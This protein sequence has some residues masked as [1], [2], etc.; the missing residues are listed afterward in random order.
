MTLNTILAALNSKAASVQTSAGNWNPLVFVAV[1]VAVIIIILILRAFGNSSRGKFEQR[2]FLSGN[3]D[4][5]TD[6]LRA[7]NVYWGFFDGLKSVYTPLVAMHTG[8]IIDYLGIFI[9]MLAL[10][11]VL[12]ILL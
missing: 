1:F 10:V 4:Y 7:S 6:N 12:V 3:V 8:Y 9:V 11:M 5:K 2:P